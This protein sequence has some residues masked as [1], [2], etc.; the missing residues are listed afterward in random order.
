MENKVTDLREKLR[1]VSE[2]EASM[3]AEEILTD[4]R[5]VLDRSG[6]MSGIAKSTI[7]GFNSFIEEQKAVPGKAIVSLLQ[8]DDELE[9][10]FNEI[11]IGH[12]PLLTRENFI[13]RNSTALYDAIGKAVADARI[14][15]A[16]KANEDRPDKVIFVIMT[17][18]LENASQEYKRNP[19]AIKILLEEH[20]DLDD[21]AFVFL[22]ANQN[23]VLEGGKL[24][25]DPGYSKTYV[26]SSVGTGAAYSSVTRGM[27]AYRVSSPIGANAACFFDEDGNV[28]ALED[29][30]IVNVTTVSNT[31]SSES[32]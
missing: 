8:F 13:P 16:K 17:D 18:G 23:A 28:T 32:K 10:V 26:A 15:I 2:E 27:T 21:W 25:F 1:R 9:Y 22:G 4:I 11:P 24:G 19:E 5:M 6:S 31:T 3:P 14:S 20:K 30:K 12:V 29:A 7:E